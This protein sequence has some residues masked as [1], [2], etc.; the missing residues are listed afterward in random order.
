MRSGNR[1]PCALVL[2]NAQVSAASWQRTN[3][4]S[5]NAELRRLFPQEWEQICRLRER[6]VLSLDPEYQE[7]SRASCPTS[8]GSIRGTTPR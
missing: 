8:S 3:I 6:G 4:D 5:V 2:S 7:L 1:A